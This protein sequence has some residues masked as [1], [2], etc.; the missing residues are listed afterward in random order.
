MQC[1]P[2]HT[3][4]QPFLFIYS[5]VHKGVVLGPIPF[6]CYTSLLFLNFSSAKIKCL[7]LIQNS[8]TK[9]LC[10]LFTNLLFLVILLPHIFGPPVTSHLKLSNQPIY[11]TVSEPWNDLPPNSADPPPIS[12]LAHHHLHHAPIYMTLR[13]S[14]PD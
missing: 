7:Q 14:T 11:H 4:L 8:Q 10:D 2:S 6:I 3:L 13:V 12:L 5:S 9:Y 1:N